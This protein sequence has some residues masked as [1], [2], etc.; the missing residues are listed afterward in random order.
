MPSVGFWEWLMFGRSSNSK[1]KLW[2]RSTSEL[3]WPNDHRFSAKLVPTFADRECRAVNVMDPYGCILGFVDQNCYFI[4][5]VAPHLYSQ[6]WV[7]PLPDP[8]LLRKSG[9][10]RNG[11]WDLWICSQKL[12]PV[13][14][15]GRHMKVIELIIPLFAV[16]LCHVLYKK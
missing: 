10:A 9:S 8:L 11:T 5:Q 6:G 14:H 4:F 12:W 13:D 15:R 2:P 3:Y 16:L 7:D 1:N